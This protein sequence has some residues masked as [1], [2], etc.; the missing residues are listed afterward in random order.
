MLKAINSPAAQAVGRF[1]YH[2]DQQQ[3]TQYFPEVTPSTFIGHADFW[4]TD[5]EGADHI[6]QNLE[7]VEFFLK[8]Q[9][10]AL[11]QAHA[12]SFA[13]ELACY[14]SFAAQAS[15]AKAGIVLPFT[16][17][18]PTAS[19][20]MQH[21][22]SAAS[23]AQQKDEPVLCVV[24]ATGLFAQA[25]DQLSDD[26]CMHRLI[27]SLNV[28]QNL[29]ALGFVHGDLKIQHFRLWQERAYLIDFEQ[30][31]RLGQDSVAAHTAT[32]RYMAPE[33]FHALPKSLASDI[34]ALGVI[35]QMW[36]NQARPA[37]RQYREWAIGH[38]QLFEVALVDRFSHCL[39]VLERMLDKNK[40][41]RYAD[42]SEIKQGLIKL[43]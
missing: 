37:Q 34:Y 42:I 10:T 21:R 28:L 31:Q 13:H 8:W 11:S 3:L 18:A 6:S 35:W 15:C 17:L 38:C 19:M 26:A 39:P 32:P 36:L 14:Q 43:L 23:E 40:A 4:P 30:C 20:L 29:H 22:D 27:Q 1:I 7:D 16:I 41:Q 24:A 12:H 9:Q 25:P 33:L 5:L 2:L